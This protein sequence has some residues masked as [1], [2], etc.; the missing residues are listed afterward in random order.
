MELNPPEPDLQA[1]LPA[2]PEEEPTSGVSS[3]APRTAQNQGAGS[4]S[5]GSRASLPP[6]NQER[7]NR[8]LQ[9][10]ADGEAAGLPAFRGMSAYAQSL[11]FSLGGP[12]ET[13]TGGAGAP[14]LEGESGVMGAVDPNYQ[15][16]S[17]PVDANFVVDQFMGHGLPQHVA[18]G[19]AANV[20]VESAFNPA[21]DTGDGGHAWGLFQHNDRR[22]AMVNWVTQHY[23]DW[24]SPEGQIAFAM[25]ELKTTERAA[26]DKIMRATTPEQAAELISRYFE[27]PGTPHMEQRLAAARQIAAGYQSA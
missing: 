27:R 12:A 21:V 8:M 14:G 18:I 1:D 13:A 22:E 17:G 23:G 3:G 16:P 4:M 7:V 19:F 25:H 5:N 26:Y 6:V 10:I 24:R 11:G 2:I 20:A 15:L 9:I